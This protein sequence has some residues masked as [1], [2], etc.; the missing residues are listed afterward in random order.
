MEEPVARWEIWSVARMLIATHGEAAEEK[1]EIEIAAALD[2]NEIGQCTVWS[3][4]R[5]KIDE[6]RDKQGTGN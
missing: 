5:A 3:A 1:A 2:A 4:I 6:I